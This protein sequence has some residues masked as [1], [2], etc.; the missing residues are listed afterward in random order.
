MQCFVLTEKVRHITKPME[1]QPVQWVMTVRSQLK[2][3]LT[4]PIRELLGCCLSIRIDISV[5][6][7]ISDNCHPYSNEVCMLQIGSTC[8]TLQ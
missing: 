5:D 7:A 6:Q 3:Q 8:K 4:C 1:Y 2:K